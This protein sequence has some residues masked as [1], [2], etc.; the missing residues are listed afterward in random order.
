MLLLCVLYFFLNHLTNKSMTD[1]LEKVTKIRLEK[2]E[3]TLKKIQSFNQN[4]KRF[5]DKDEKTNDDNKESSELSDDQNNQNP[6]EIK[7][8]LG[9]NALK[10]GKTSMGPVSSNLV[11]SNG[12]NTDTKK[13]I[14]LNVLNHS[15][16]HSVFIF[17]ILCGFL[18]PIYIYSNNM[19]YN[20]NQLL[21]VQNHIFGELIKSS[22]STVEVKCFMSYCQNS[23]ALYY[24]DLVDMDKIQQVIK[25]I[26]TF[27]EVKNFY[28]EKFL[29]N[30][31]AAAID[32]ITKEEE[33]NECLNESLI[34]S[35][36]NTDNLI[37]LVDDIVDNIYKEDNMTAKE[38]QGKNLYMRF[39]LFN[40]SYFN[41]MEA[42]FYKYIIPVGD[43]FANLVNEDLDNYLTERKILVLI[44][45]CVLG[46]IIIIYSLIFGIIFINQ[47]IHYLSVSR[48]IM[49]IIPTSVI[50]STQDL[51]TWIENKY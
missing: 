39:Q 7:K 18:I 9:V 29:L 19:V 15:F 27:S 32:K 22:A 5:R 35:A 34:V 13:Y 37:K 30:A 33:Y 8:T 26:G 12:F 25:G 28:N 45:V 49:K 6:N 36:N 47:L 10:K 16:L 20:T 38:D 24:S 42:I 48:C 40:T 50:I 46:T 11:N 1:G 21:L 43:I 23:S 44:L 4:L 31:C 51:E 14:P 41:Q 2:I 17:C 3:E